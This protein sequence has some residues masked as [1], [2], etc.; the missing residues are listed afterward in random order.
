MTS[1]SVLYTDSYDIPQL[2][3]T[4]EDK[5]YECTVL[6]NSTLPVMA[7]NIVTL[8]VTGKYNYIY[9]PFIAIIVNVYSSLCKHRHNTY[10]SHT[11][12]YGGQSTR[13]PVY[14]EYS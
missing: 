6:V 13:Y 10:W 14:S 1:Y 7:T 4:D 12:S 5:T 11:R 9:H 2:S 3:T 8:N